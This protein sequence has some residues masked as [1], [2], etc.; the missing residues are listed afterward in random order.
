MALRGVSEEAVDHVLTDYDTR[1]PRKRHLPGHE[2]V[3]EH[4]GRRLKVVVDDVSNLVASIITTHWM[5][6]PEGGN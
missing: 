4:G 6:E 2:Y 1:L 3:G 5:D